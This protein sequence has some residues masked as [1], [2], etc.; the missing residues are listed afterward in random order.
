MYV[1]WPL[2]ENQG[3]KY[4]VMALGSCVKWGWKSCFTFE[5]MWACAN[6][7]YRWRDQL[8]SMFTRYQYQP[9]KPFLSIYKG[10]L[11]KQVATHS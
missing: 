4:M 3:P 1:V 9:F 11:T 6:A 10:V 8:K 5:S 7:V 2:D